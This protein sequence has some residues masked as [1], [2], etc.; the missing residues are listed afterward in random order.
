MKTS[1]YVVA[2]AAVVLGAC[3]KEV[4]DGV[5]PTTP[6]RFED[7]QV[8]ANFDWKTTQDVTINIEGIPTP[9]PV[10]STLVIMDV[11]GRAIHKALHTMSETESLSMTLPAHIKSLVVKYGSNQ[12]EFAIEN[13]TV[14]VSFL[15]E[16]RDQ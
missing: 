4:N 14:Q 8:D 9:V 15:P 3:S 7:L 5:N 13:G 6:A 16:D 11:Q 12:K 1:I 2:F 10:Q